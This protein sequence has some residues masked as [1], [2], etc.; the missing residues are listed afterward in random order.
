VNPLDLLP[1]AVVR[2]A[3]VF[4][5]FF[6]G[7]LSAIAMHLLAPNVSQPLDLRGG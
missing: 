3:G 5:P 1:V 2:L 6:A 7:F 4:V